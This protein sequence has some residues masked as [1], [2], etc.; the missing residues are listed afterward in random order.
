MSLGFDSPR[1]IIRVAPLTSHHGWK[2][3]TMF[4]ANPFGI[5]AGSKTSMRDHIDGNCGQAPGEINRV[6]LQAGQP[7]RNG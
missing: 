6:M 7:G 3:M 5:V 4:P 2:L 1:S